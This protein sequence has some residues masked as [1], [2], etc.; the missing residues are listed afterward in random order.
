[1]TGSCI[2]VLMLAGPAAA[3]GR[4]NI[5]VVC[6][7]DLSPFFGCYGHAEAR[8]PNIDA[9]AAGSTL[10]RHALTTAPICAPSRSSLVSGM[11]A[12]SLGTQHLR[13][14]VQI[15]TAVRPLPKVLKEHGYWT[16][17]RG[18]SDYNFSA[19]GLYDSWVGAET[20]P[21]E[22]CPEGR[23]FYVFMNLGATHEGTGNA[24]ARA[25]RFLKK[26]GHRRDPATCVP[27]PYYPDTPRMRELW[28][29]YHDLA[30]GFDID[31]GETLARL[32][33]DGLADNTIVV[34]LS[35]HGHGMPRYKRWL[36]LTGL[37][38]PLIVHVPGQAG[39]AVERPV[40]MIDLPATVLAL[41]GA[42]VPDVYQG[43][44]LETDGGGGN[45]LP[46]FAARDRADDM[47]DLSRLVFDGEYV[48]IRHFT[49]YL[50]YL[51]EGYIFS[52]AKDSLRELRR[53][54]LAGEDT[55][56]SAKLWSPRPLE[57][58]YHIPSDPE[59]LVNLA[60]DPAHQETQQR[61]AGTLKQHILAV[62]DTG[63]LWEPEMHRRAVE[64]GVTP[65]E[66]ARDPALYPLERV[67]DAAWRAGAED[68]ADL[69]SDPDPAVRFW[70]LQSE[71]IR[72]QRRP[73]LV[74]PLL[75]DGNA[76][77]E[78]TA[79]EVLARSGETQPARSV[80]L[81]YLNAAE[82]RLQLYNA[83][84]LALS[85]DDVGP[86]EPEVRDALLRLRDPGGNPYVPYKD[87]MYSAFTSWALESS[88]VKSGLA[89]FKDFK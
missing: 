72:G 70:A 13:S 81:R 35:D 31:F 40:S 61:L 69:L 86:I 14:E 39:R 55:A 4:P 8:T 30:T 17:I 16:A 84:A 89:E 85:L 43:K 65:F 64:N 82:P 18:K 29:R 79:A 1:M 26:V 56:E 3:A 51:Q 21:W 2:L 78:V 11:H 41:A 77:V 87:F 73:G 54:H 46:I 33:A 47:Y 80:F 37:H 60:G 44:P 6:A 53:V 20:V 63:F 38:V 76:L 19:K 5:L 32:E 42:E 52:D 15:P 45:R 23:P 68:L 67:V 50:P 7:E 25:E 9:F 28:A 83:R 34:L 48:Y 22:A 49:P 57:E 66:V 59:E 88:L 75:E 58:L 36:Y 24:A 27:P 12:E 62:R 10:F 71:L 74:R